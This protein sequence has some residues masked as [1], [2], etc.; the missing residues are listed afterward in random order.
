M[1]SRAIPRVFRENK[2][3]FV[4][5][6]KRIL[7][8][9]IM[10]KTNVTILLTILKIIAIAIPLLLIFKQVDLSKIGSAI[11]QVRWWAIPVHLL[12]GLLMMI[13][14]GVR[15]WILIKAFTNKLSLLRSMA[16]HFSSIFYSLI[17]PNSIS[18]EI[19][20]TVFATKQAGSII[21]WS[22][23]WIAKIL[24]I[25]V[26]LGF[27][28]CG[29]ALLSG[30]GIPNS[31]TVII[32]VL[33]GILL[34]TIILSFS[35]KSTRLLRKIFLPLIPKRFLGWIENFR[36]GIYQYRNKKRSLVIVFFCTVLVQLIMVF[37]I[38]ALLFG[39]TGRFYLT[40]CMAYIPLIEMIC[41]AQPFTPNGIGVREAL[42]AI[43]F[44]QL[45]LT[46]EQLGIYIIISNL[47]ILLKFLGVIPVLY[48]F[49][50][51][52]QR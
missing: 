21:S 48:G 34:L 19:I 25:I 8:I 5:T 27:S 2:K 50:M 47:A 4:G 30:T 33:F 11:Q 17:I 1:K 37:G 20:R 13:L 9:N 40:E 49:N 41:M 24:G 39:I 10:K 36:E 14:Q 12:T 42:V 51:K 38:T 3:H 23:S 35:K 45:G 32:I 16:Y 43:M 29:L 31:V 22:S 26:S 28:L 18:Q 46:N 6:L 52:E 7:H 15:W 44:K